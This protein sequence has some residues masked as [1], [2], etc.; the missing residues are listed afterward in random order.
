MYLTLLK[1]CL[2]DLHR[3]GQPEY[4]PIISNK[5]RKITMAVMIWLNKILKPFDISICKIK[6]PTLEQ[7]RNGRDWP[8]YADTMIGEKR[9]DNIGQLINNICFYSI[10]GDFIET[11][12]WRGGASIFMKGSLNHWKYQ[13]DENR[14]IY[15]CDSFEGLP[16]PEHGKDRGSTFHLQHELAVPLEVVKYNFEKYGLLD[17]N[18]VFVKGWFKDTLHKIEAEKF[19]LIRLDGDMYASTMDALNALYHK[20]SIGGYIIIDDYGS[21][22]QCKLAVDEYRAEHG[23]EDEMIDIDGEG[24][25]WRKIK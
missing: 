11:G 13:E 2:L 18:V 19:A 20:L 23:I 7:R 25:Y 21:V 9:L 10:P 22:P 17:D 5:N 12:V 24:V 15:V 8:G 1:N 6:N 3:I 14:K 16:K 4:V